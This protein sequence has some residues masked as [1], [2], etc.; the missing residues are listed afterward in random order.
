MASISS[1]IWRAGLT[2][3]PRNAV[4]IREAWLNTGV[5]KVFT[6]AA[7]GVLITLAAGHLNNSR[8]A[9]VHKLK[10]IC[11]D[12]S[13]VRSPV[14]VPLAPSWTGQ[15]CES[16]LKATQS[17]AW[18]CSRLSVLPLSE[19]TSSAGILGRVRWVRNGGGGRA[20]PQSKNRPKSM[21]LGHEA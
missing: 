13:A 14:S 1:H 6:K 18:P 4:H 17:P 5:L 12:A 11:P 9:G 10:N 19:Y 3:L 8:D 16:L 15:D 7:K 20:K 21:D 2:A